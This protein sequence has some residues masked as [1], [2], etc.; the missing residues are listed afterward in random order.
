MFNE[1]L[2]QKI[3]ES[4]KLSRKEDDL[5][6]ELI[7]W[8]YKKTDFNLNCDVKILRSAEKICKRLK[9]NKELQLLRKAI[10]E[11]SQ[12]KAGLKLF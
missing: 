5:E 8:H 7:L 2:F 12:Q 10:R 3:Y 11:K 6:T 9:F 1:A 4:A